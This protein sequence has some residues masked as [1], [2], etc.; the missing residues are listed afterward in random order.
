MDTELSEWNIKNIH[1]LILKE[2]NNSNAGKYRNENVSI[3]G[4]T[5]VPI[6]YINVPEEMEK[7]IIKYNDWEEYH[8]LIRAALLH[9]EFVFIHPF[10]DSNG[11]IARLLMNYEAMKNGYLLIIIRKDIRFKYYEALDKAMV[12]HDYTEFVKLVVEE[13]IKMLDR[14]LELIG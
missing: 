12:F 3:I 11:R 7:L 8:S 13:E 5:Q 10:I 1:A 9:G 14:Y 6:D 2:I 4:A